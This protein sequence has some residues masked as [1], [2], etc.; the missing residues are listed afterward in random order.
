MGAT[1]QGVSRLLVALMLFPV[2]VISG[3]FC[4][5]KDE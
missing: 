2:M 4:S 5:G 1:G 3:L